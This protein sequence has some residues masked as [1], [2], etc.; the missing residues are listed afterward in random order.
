MATVRPI[1]RGKAKIMSLLPGLLLGVVGG[2]LN[3]SFTA[4]MKFSSNWAWENSW[5]IYSVI[6]LLCIPIAIA[7]IFVPDLVAVYQAASPGAVAL[8]MLFGFGW[9]VGSVLFGLGIHMLGMALGFAII[10]GLTA[11][12][13]SLIP[14][15]VL[16]PQ[17]LFTAHGVSVLVGLA[18]V[19]CG[20]IVCA[21]AGAMKNASSASEGTR[22]RAGFL[23]C[24]GSGIFSSMLNLALAFGAP[25]A[26]AAVQAGATP[27]AAQ[28]AIWALAVGA[29]SLANIGYSL[30]L[31]FRNKSWNRFSTSGSGK[32]ILLATAMGILWMAG[33][34]VYGAG[35]AALGGLGPVIGWPLFMSTVIIT[36]NVWG[37]ATG[38]WKQAHPAALRLNLVGVALLIAAIAVISVG[39]ARS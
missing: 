18:I 11:A 21:K 39:S 5:L 26:E 14:L 15:I 7:L 34:S 30:G 10:L 37:F 12:L 25:I 31:L 8:A 35:A 24:I 6:G 9:G 28:N 36:G 2:M 27:G 1:N 4:P 19:V 3:G 33:V 32:N 22:F 29:G 16:S 17:A 23:I 20:I 38:E 13:G